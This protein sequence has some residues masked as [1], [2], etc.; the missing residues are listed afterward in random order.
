[1]YYFDPD[2]GTRRRSLMRDRVNRARSKARRT[3]DAA[4][5]DVTN[6]TRGTF[7]ELRGAIGSQFV[8]DEVLV[9]RVRSKLGRCVSQ[10][11]SIQVSAHD[12]CVALSGSVVAGEIRNLLSAVQAIHGV[13][14]ISNALEMNDEAENASELRGGLSRLSELGGFAQRRWS[15]NTRV[16]AGTAGAALMVN[17]LARRTP[18]AALAGAFGFGLSLRALTNLETKRLL[19]T[20]RWRRRIDIHK[21]IVI[22]APIGR[23]FA[24]LSDP[25]NYPR[26]TTSV[27]SV[28]ALGDDRY[29]K[30]IGGPGGAEIKLEE[31]ITER[32]QNDLFAWRSGPNSTLKYA[33]T[34]RFT[35]LG[36]DRTQVHFCFTYNPP[37]GIIGHAAAWLAGSDPK[38]QLDEI[39]MRAKSYLETGVQPQDAANRSQP[40][41]REVERQ[42]T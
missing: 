29:E 22:D 37:G 5:K 36:N 17:C 1:M 34:A 9:E 21:T 33:G 35:D 25:E 18:M 7:A 4:V 2:R 12:G 6:R 27:K 24:L 28:Q 20:A 23:V 30:T 16:A 3:A 11:S 32:H 26:F 40:E 8:P 42:S 10:P 13:I 38:H 15:P 39:L 41:I 31:T 14:G 19:G